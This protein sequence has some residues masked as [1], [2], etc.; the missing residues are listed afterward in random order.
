[1]ARLA[2]RSKLTVLASALVI[3][4]AAGIAAYLLS[5][6]QPVDNAEQG[7]LD[8]RFLYRGPIGEKPNRIALVTVD[9]QAK[10]PYWAP[11]PREHLASVITGLSNAGARLIGVDFFL[12]SHSFDARGDSLL[13]QAIEQAGNVVIVSYLDRGAEGQLEEH[14]ALPF[15][16]D[17]AL[18]YGYATFFTGTSVESVREGRTAVSMDG[19]H[20]LSLAG[21]LFAH[22]QGLDTGSIR[23]LEWSRRQPE[24]PGSEDDYAR[25]IDYNGPPYQYYRGLDRELQG[26]IAAFHSKDV[27]SL[28]AVVTQRFFKDRI[29]L[30]GSGL[31][32]AP[33]IYRTPFFSQEFGFERTFGVEI[34]GHFLNSMLSPQPLETSGFF[35]TAIIVLLPAFLCALVAVRLRPYIAFPLVLVVLGGVWAYG[36]H[37]FSA[38]ALV[39]PLVMPTVGA[40]LACLIGFMYVGSTEGRRKSEVRD[41]FAP[42]VG[43]QQLKQ[44]LEEPDAWSTDGEERIVSVLWL[45]LNAPD[46]GTG[47]AASARETVVFFQQYWDAMSQVVFKH[48]GA[49]FRYEEDAMAA[50]FGAPVN[51]R[52]H[53]S[54]AVMAAIDAADAWPSLR[55][56]GGAVS[57]AWTLAAGADSGRAILGEMGGDEHYAYR[58]QG[59]PVERSRQLASQQSS[60]SE[61]WI[62]Q[63][64][65]DLVQGQIES[66]PLDS[67]GGTT[68]RVTGRFAA[69]PIGAAEGLTNPFWK[70][71]GLARREQD[72]V[73]GELLGRLALFSDFNKQELG[74][75]RSIVHH[76]TYTG[77]ERV[78]SQGEVGSAMYI[79]QKGRIDILQEREDGGTDLLQRL[80]EGDFFGEL[81][82][83]SDLPRP[84]AAVAYEASELLVLFQSDLF[85]LIERAPELGVRL[86]RSLS[87]ILGE[88]LIQVN[89]QL[90]RQGRDTEGD[91][92]P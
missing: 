79:V 64:L 62:S 43:E 84:A 88:R 58:V 80:D 70:Y 45:Q 29:V 68:H 69:P 61:V 71:V 2:S 21:C 33:D 76:R 15:F 9:E 77:G 13:R 32:D 54:H 59:R 78:F 31:S 73:S 74:Q 55:A 90:V 12:G 50:V 1:M 57:A 60:G 28:P 35:R 23:Q 27:V 26:G 34:H 36:F 22:D 42:M 10:L 48:G 86:I 40:G 17:V 37:L 65:S 81:A 56:T 91:S 16:L 6:L 38:D 85:D 49:V 83:L 47:G 82:L 25:I 24:L 11:V 66:E 72:P 44:L 14:T 8:W 7:T 87:R 41:R 5:L 4:Y 52:D 53:P 63:E 67:E 75:M 30:L 3:A 51:D 46:T 92:R 18:D 19:R 20:A 89:E 39:V